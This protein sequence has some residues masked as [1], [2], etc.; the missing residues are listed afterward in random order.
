VQRIEEIAREKGCTPAQLA[1]AWL[2]T[3]GDDIVPIPG[4]RRI[5]HLEENV[6]A[7]DVELT[8]RDL[9]RIDEA[10]P[11]GIT[12]GDRYPDMSRVNV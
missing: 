11:K 4:V 7:L 12:A 10:S 3:R 9:E 8:R 5:P 1:L 6:E 2:L